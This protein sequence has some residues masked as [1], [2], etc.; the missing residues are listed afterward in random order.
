MANQFDTGDRMK[1]AVYGTL[2]QGHCRHELLANCRYWG[3]DQ[4]LPMYTLWDL[5]DF[6]A[7]TLGGKTSI[8]VEVYQ[9]TPLLL[10]QLDQIEGHPYFYERLLTPL[11]M[12][13]Q[14]FMYVLS[15]FSEKRL[16]EWNARKIQVGTWSP[17]IRG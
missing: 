4:T 14:T 9:V 7:V 11:Y 13:E 2:K 12:H 17:L 3:K 8:Q 15:R 5:G 6:P 1:L 10:L 16:E